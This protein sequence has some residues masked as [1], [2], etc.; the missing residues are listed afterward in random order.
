VTDAGASAALSCSALLEAL[1]EAAWAVGSRQEVV[2]I[3]RAALVLLGL[4]REHAVGRQ[5]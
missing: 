2:A 3:N 4:A 5:A 1:N